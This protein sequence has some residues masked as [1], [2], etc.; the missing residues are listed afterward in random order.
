MCIVALAWQVFDQ[1]PLCLLSNRDEFYARPTT[2]LHL[3]ENTPIIA[4]RDLQSG[5]TWMGITASGRWAVVTNFRDGHDKKIYD[6]SRGTLV[7][8]FLLSDLAPIRFAKQLEQRQQHYAGFNLFMGD[9]SQ[10]VY[11]S[12]RGEAPQVLAKGVYVVSNGLMSE[13]WEKTA[14]LRKRFTQ[15]FVPMLQAEIAEHD[16]EYTAWDILEDERKVIPE[17]LPS[18][19]IHPD[20]EELLSSTFIQSPV[21][22]TRCSNFLRLMKRRW[23]WAEKTQWGDHAGEMMRMDIQIQ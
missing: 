8:D 17:L 1:I 20:M 4:G 14:H 16:L 6:T 18:T 2:Q 11:M 13:H 7:E 5:G 23:I 21:Y 12:N 15:E 9:Q 10:A 22:G 19:G 3:W